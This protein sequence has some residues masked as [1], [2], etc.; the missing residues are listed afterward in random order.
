MTLH[1]EH[2]VYSGEGLAHT[3]TGAPVLVPFTLPGEVV[4]LDGPSDALQILT[5]SSDRIAPRCVHFGACG[6]CQYQHIDYPAQVAVKASILQQTLAGAGLT[7]LPELQSHAADPYHYRNRIRLRFEVVDGALRF[8]Y[9]RR[10]SYDMLPIVECPISAPLLLRT[11]EALLLVAAGNPAWQRHLAAAELFIN[12]DESR[13]QVTLFVRSDRVLILNIFCEQLK[14]HI[15]ELAGAGITVVGP[16]GR[17]DQPGANWGAPG[18]M[19]HTADRDYWVS[20]GSFFQVNRFLVEALLNLATTDRTGTLAWDLY[21]GVG[22]FSRVLADSFAQVIGVETI[23]GDLAASL[24]GPGKQAV[25]A[26]T[27]EF[28]RHAVLQRERPGFI[29]MDPPRAGLGPEVCALLARVKAPQMVYVS[30]DPQT[31]AQDLKAMVD[32]GY[33]IHALHL[34]DLFPQTFHLETVVFL[35]R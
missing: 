17:K 6:G 27:L 2:L 13:V 12:A 16:S 1:I 19:V 33:T 4:R 8:G 28:L 32:S 35:N 3:E 24:K 34:V 26:T 31:L 7:A 9:N 10:G 5:A 21:A 22:L 23:V 25:G 30:C 20:R 15:P 18:M 14:M 29:V 11:A